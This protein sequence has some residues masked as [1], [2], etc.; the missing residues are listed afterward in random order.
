MKII[1]QIEIIDETKIINEAFKRKLSLKGVYE[2]YALYVDGVAVSIAAIQYKKDR[3]I[4]KFEYTPEEYQK[5]GFH[6]KLLKYRIELCKSKG[7]KKIEANCLKPSLNNH[8]KLGAKIIK[9]YK[10]C[11][12]LVR[13]EDI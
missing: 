6:T 9:Q 13:Y 2:L 4:L 8:L 1:K 10:H 11:G 3:A 5:K 12:A 7:I